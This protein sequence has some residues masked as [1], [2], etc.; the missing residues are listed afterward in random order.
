M[1]ER[2]LIVGLG[3]PG[4][5]YETTRHNL[6]FWV[7]DE[8]ARR[9]DIRDATKERK[10]I[11]A[12]GI[13]RGKRALLAKPQTYMNNSGQSVRALIDFYK[14][15]IDNL[16]VVHDDIDIDLGTLR[17]RPTGSSGGQNGIRDIIRHLGTSDFKRIRCGV[18]RP[19]GRMDPAA[20]VLQPFTSDQAITASRV[21]D[22]AADAIEAWLVDGFE[23][24]MNVYN[25]KLE[26]IPRPESGD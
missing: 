23:R 6:G 17:L 13:I 22:R 21:V 5:K 19:P 9:W 26:D 12:D 10:A 3:N 25:G 2:Y 8:L 11:T 4:K 24:A 18:S 14:L 15:E 20:Y 7:I 1:S 16:M